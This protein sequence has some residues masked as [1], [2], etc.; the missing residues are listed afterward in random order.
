[1]KRPAHAAASRR[2]EDVLPPLYKRLGGNDWRERLDALAE[3]ADMLIVN[4]HELTATGKVVQVLDVVCER[5]GDGNLKVGKRPTRRPQYTFGCISYF[6]A[7][8]LWN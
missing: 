7:F 8:S 5:L 4:V 6:F 3:V 1:M 2:W